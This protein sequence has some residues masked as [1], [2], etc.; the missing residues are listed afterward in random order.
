[1]SPDLQLTLPARAKSVA[2]ARAAAGPL[3]AGLSADVREGVRVVISEL[4]T[5]AVRHGPGGTVT[6]RLRRDGPAI[7]GEVQD[8]GEEMAVPPSDAGGPHGGF[9][10]RVVNALSDRWG[11]SEGSTHVWFELSDR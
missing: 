7:H 1:V 10:L 11:V 3:L 5:N 6:L 9:G 2:E 4:V 8:D